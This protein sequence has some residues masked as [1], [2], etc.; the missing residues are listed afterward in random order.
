M[1][2]GKC[3][4]E[5]VQDTAFCSQCGASLEMEEPN[6]NTNTQEIKS[7]SQNRKVGI[8]VFA[9]LVGVVMITIL[10][11]LGGRSY[12]STI[13]K[14]FE[15]TINADAK[16]IIKLI[17][18]SVIEEALKEEG[19]EKKEKKLFIEEGEKKLQESIDTINDTAGEDWKLTHEIIDTEDITGKDLKEVKEDYEDLNIKISKAKKVEVKIKIKPADSD[20]ENTATTKLYLIKSGRNWYLDIKNMSSIF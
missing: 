4:A 16:K 3:G 13:N 20:K 12:K 17:P 9:A 8:I 2:C 19:Y 1:Y 5:I 15:A 18:E 7:D 10:Y 11:I 6:L 14:Y